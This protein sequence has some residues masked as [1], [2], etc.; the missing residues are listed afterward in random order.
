[1]LVS[2]VARQ[3]RVPGVGPLLPAFTTQ[4]NPG[5][6]TWRAITGEENLG[7]FLPRNLQGD[8]KGDML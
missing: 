6:R 1:M 2:Y 3:V 8:A 4:A 7:Q 5:T